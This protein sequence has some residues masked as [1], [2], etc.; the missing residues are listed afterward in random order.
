[1]N[2]LFSTINIDNSTAILFLDNKIVCKK[3]SK[4]KLNN[5]SSPYITTRNIQ[6]LFSVG[7]FDRISNTKDCN[8]GK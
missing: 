4:S 1:M 3:L 8:C 2:L 6:P 7:M 5:Q